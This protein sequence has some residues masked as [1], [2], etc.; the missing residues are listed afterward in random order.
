M[1]S[2]RTLNSK[3]IPFISTKAAKEAF[4]IVHRIS[5]TPQQEKRKSASFYFGPFGFAEATKMCQ[6]SSVSM[7]HKNY[8]C[9]TTVTFWGWPNRANMKVLEFQYFGNLLGL[10]VKMT[11]KYN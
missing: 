3:L 5:V 9:I 7:Q 2:V 1:H 8:Y 4:W 11:N 6:L 10:H